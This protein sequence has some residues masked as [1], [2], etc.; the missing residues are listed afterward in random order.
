MDGFSVAFLRRREL[1]NWMLRLKM[2]KNLNLGWKSVPEIAL[3]LISLG[4]ER[5]VISTTLNLYPQ[6][7][8]SPRHWRNRA[9]GKRLQAEVLPCTL[10]RMKV[11]K[12][13][14]RGD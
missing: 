9:K 8:V 11:F 2:N 12:K 14:I 10:V 5:T 6:V 3:L 4:K 7:H 1:P 13:A